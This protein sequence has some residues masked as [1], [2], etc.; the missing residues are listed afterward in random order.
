MCQQPYRECNQQR[1]GGPRRPGEREL[2]DEH[3]AERELD[4]REYGN[5]TGDRLGDT[6]NEKHRAEERG[7]YDSKRP[8]PAR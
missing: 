8:K 7:G 4:P 2:G 6:R 1:D 5:V 3:A